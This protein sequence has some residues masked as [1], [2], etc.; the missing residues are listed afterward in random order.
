MGRFGAQSERGGLTP[1]KEELEHLYELQQIDTQLREAETALAKLDDGTADRAKL[2]AA[3]EEAAERQGRLARH[4]AMRRDKE[5]ELGTTEAKR[6]QSMDRAYGG[7]ISNPKEL[8]SLEMEIE[9]LGRAKDRLEEIIIDL[10]EKLD[11]DEEAVAE[12]ERIVSDLSERV[13]ALEKTYAAETERL[14]AEIET[15]RRRRAE[16]VGRVSP[17]TLGHY[18]MLLRKNGNLAIVRVIDGV[19]EGC[20]IRVSLIKIQKLETTGDETFCDN[21]KRYLYVEG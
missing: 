11:E 2:A 3:K 19:C 10:L 6:K 9:A 4:E 5:L 7:T 8:G 16:V 20:N 17:R 18:E 1:M 14:S 12:Q 13:A 21:C 15:L